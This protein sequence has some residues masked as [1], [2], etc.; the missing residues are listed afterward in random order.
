V[1]N[2]ASGK[3]RL[4]KNEHDSARMAQ[5][6]EREE[7]PLKVCVTFSS[8]VSMDQMIFGPG[9]LVDANVYVYVGGN[10]VTGM[11]PSGHGAL[12]DLLTAIGIGLTVFQIRNSILF[13]AH[14]TPLNLLFVGFGV[15]LFPWSEFKAAA[16]VAEGVPAASQWFGNLLK[17]ARAVRNPS[18]V[19][20][21]TWLESRGFQFALR[22]KDILRLWG[23]TVPQGKKAV[24][25]IAETGSNQI[26]MVEAKAGLSTSRLEE[27][28]SGGGKFG[29]SFEALTKYMQAN[30]QA[31]PTVKEAWITY[32][33]L[34]G[35]APP[36]SLGPNGE[37]MKDGIVQT[38]D[39]V[40]ICAKKV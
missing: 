13:P 2:R 21:A 4:F 9:Q 1:L 29:D 23:D 36:W 28:F 12:L 14:R 15:V 5:A 8:Y 34:T 31:A 22:E 32:T 6:K 33:E 3:L 11:D 38:I 20:A 10:P 19:Q 18:E 26:V 30:G 7:R 27:T 40:T 17:Y 39:G 35:I 37:V 25:F 24:D 16:D